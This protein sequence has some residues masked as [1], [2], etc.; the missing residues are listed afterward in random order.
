MSRFT[1]HNTTPSTL[2]QFYNSIINNQHHVTV[3]DINGHRGKG[4]F[5]TRSFS[6]DE[7]ILSERPL[8]ALQHVSNRQSAACC[9]Q[10]FKFL[11]NLQEQIQYH[12]QSLNLLD[13][14]EEMM[15]DEDA[16]VVAPIFHFETS[17]ECVGNCGILY[18]SDN[19]RS[20]AY[21][22]HHKHLCVG[23]IQE[24]EHPLILFK[25]HAVEHNELFLMAATAICQIISTWQQNGHNLI[26]ATLPYSSLLQRHYIDAID[27][28]MNAD[29]SKE[30]V[31]QLMHESLELLTEVLKSIIQSIE[32]GKELEQLLNMDFYSRLLGTFETNNQTIEIEAPLQQY[33]K[34]CRSDQEWNNI[35]SVANRILKMQ[36]EMEQDE[37]MEC[38][39]EECDHHDHHDHDHHHHHEHHEHHDDTSFEPVDLSG[40]QSTKPYI[41]PPCEGLGMYILEAT[42]NHSCDPNTIV[43]NLNENQTVII[44]LRDINAGEE[45]VHSYIDN[46]ASYEERQQELSSY[47]FVCDCH[48]CEQEKN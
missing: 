35:S 20:E 13:T 10:C 8:V 28:N 19:C 16:L 32:G 9:G 36:K 27:F 47:G 7:I 39:E 30:S 38:D 2:D 12:E 25:E 48:K 3:R 1:I 24:P 17:L 6:K 40:A 5:A 37:D 42:T 18:C 31:E 26:E 45:L 21:E 23:P 15:D 4:L 43:K 29:V 14:T 46:D 41:F 33:L 44:A 11:G 34:Q 22:L